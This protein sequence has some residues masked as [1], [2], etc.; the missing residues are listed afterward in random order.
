M[1]KK[2]LVLLDKSK[3]QSVSEDLPNFILWTISAFSSWEVLPLWYLSCSTQ[4]ACHLYAI[5]QLCR[6][7]G[8]FSFHNF[9]IHYY[10]ESLWIISWLASEFIFE[11]TVKFSTFKSLFHS[12]SCKPTKI[13]LSSWYYSWGKCHEGRDFIKS[14]LVI[15]MFFHLLCCYLFAE[16][17]IRYYTFIVKAS[18][19]IL[20][21]KTVES[22]FLVP[23]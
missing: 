8:P 15:A 3:E 2:L 9:P 16:Q 14:F 17:M 19:E 7:T 1:L 21:F 5:F 11:V 4:L 12:N 20:I 13:P 23:N 18:C 10:C 6:L 22:F